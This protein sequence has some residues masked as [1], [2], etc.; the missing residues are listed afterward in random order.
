MNIIEHLV[1]K[2][3]P[4]FLSHHRP[5]TCLLAL[6]FLGRRR[7]LPL[8]R[9]AGGEPGHAG[10]VHYLILPSIHLLLHHLIPSLLLLFSC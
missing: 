3:S 2:K 8:P 5:P 1:E 10:K 4:T 7:H 6:F 9:G